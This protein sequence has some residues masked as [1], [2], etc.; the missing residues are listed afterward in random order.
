M[1]GDRLKKEPPKLT[2]PYVTKTDL[3]IPGLAQ[4]TVVMSCIKTK[5]YGAVYRVGWDYSLKPINVKLS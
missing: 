5:L 1:L 4:K 2:T 3:Y